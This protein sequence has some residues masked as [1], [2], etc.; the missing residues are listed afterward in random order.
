MRFPTGYLLHVLLTCKL[1]R[2]KK[3]VQQVLPPWLLPVIDG[4]RV[5][6]KREDEECTACGARS[7]V[8]DAV[9]GPRLLAY[10]T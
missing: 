6:N 8:V 4:N 9:A 5:G 10:L 1:N 2:M 3:K 7:I